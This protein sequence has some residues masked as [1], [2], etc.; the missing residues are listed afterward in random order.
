MRKSNNSSPSFRKKLLANSIKSLTLATVAVLPSFAVAAP[1]ALEE[2]VVT[3]TK[4]SESI[5]D[6][7]LAINA[8]SGDFAR[9]VNLNDVKDMIKFSPGISGNSQDSFL[10]TISVRGIVSNDFGNGGDPSI[11]VYKNGNYQG[12]NGSAVSSL[13]DIDRVEVL[14]GPQ[15]FLFGR[16]AISGAISSHSNKASLESQEGYLELDVGERNVFVAEGAINMP[17]NDS[18]A[19]RVAGYHSEEDGW[20]DHLPSGDKLLGHNKDAARISA[21]FVSEKIDANFY[22]EYEDRKQGGTVYVAREDQAYQA[23]NGVL[24]GAGLP[25]LA[26]RPKHGED[27]SDLDLNG[28]GQG[29]YDDG[30]VLSVGLQIDYDMENLV[31]TSITGYKS[32]HYAYAED[33]DGSSAQLFWYSQDQEGD[34]LEQEFRLTSNSD[35]ALSWYAGLSYYE[36]DI[37]TIFTG[38]QAEEIYCNIYWGGSCAYAVYLDNAYYS[39]AYFGSPGGF[40]PA[41]SGLI[42]DKNRTI[43][44]YQGYAGYVDLSYQFTETVS[45][46]A[47]VR[48]TYDEKEMSQQSLPA[49]SLFN[50]GVQAPL[51][52]GVIKDKEDWDEVTWRVVINYQPNDDTLLYFSTTT[53]S[54]SG[55]FNSFS[56]TPAG[57]KPASFDEE[58][59]ISY[60][61][62]YKGT[63]LDGRAQLTANTFYYDYTDQQLT[64]AY[65]DSPNITRVGNIGQVDGYGFEG[66][67]QAV[68]TDTLRFMLGVSWFDSE[69]NEVENFCENLDVCEGEPQPGA[70]EWTFFASLNTAIPVAGGEWF[71][72]LNYSWEDK[73][74]SSLNPNLSKD[75]RGPRELQLSAGY[76]SEQQWTVSVYVENLTD[77]EY[78]DGGV[79]NAAADGSSFYPD[80]DINP[81]RPRTAGIRLGYEF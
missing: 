49:E 81:S 7:P 9:E 31:L 57:D 51:T 17:V 42:E 22:V 76:R 78:Y 32:H 74:A 35:G 67:A 26:A 66:T 39:S 13:F 54:K 72:S 19:L 21:K 73:R 60:E 15:G 75:L 5:Q 29:I 69:V 1:M 30:N 64:F 48:Y 37:D 53:G 28:T 40:T 52:E 16:N 18:F 44:Q 46:S 56:L 25:A 59:V 23:L 55:G 24:T 27:V 34:Y 3:A 65:P 20:V 62:G 70:P 43:G 61:L 58:S 2:V 77:E 45:V 63:L 80:S 79:S 36:E 47:G 71:G 38:N 4:R 68:L 12:R 50:G 6:V 11:G 14:R 41:S 33:Y 8:I 10:D